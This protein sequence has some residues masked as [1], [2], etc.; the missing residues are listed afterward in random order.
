MACTLPEQPSEAQF[1]GFSENVPIRLQDI[2]CLFFGMILVC[3][4]AGKTDGQV[5]KNQTFEQTQTLLLTPKG[6]GMYPP[7]SLMKTTFTS[8]SSLDVAT[9]LWRLLDVIANLQCTHAY[10]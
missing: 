3:S 6:L 9:I 2:V 8:A 5:S 7:T 10:K 1:E 4:Y